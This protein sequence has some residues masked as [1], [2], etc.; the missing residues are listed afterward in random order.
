M[1]RVKRRS[2]LALFGGSPAFDPAIHVGRPN[3]GDRQA[4]DRLVREALDRRWLTN[5]GPLVRE[6]ERRIGEQLGVEHCVAV[7]N[8]TIGLEILFHALGLAGEVLVPSYTFIATAHALLRCGIKPIFVDIDPATHNIDPKAARARASSRTSGIVA[9]HLWGRPVPVRELQDLAGELGVP[10][11]FDAAHAFGCTFEGRSIGNFGAAEVLSFHATKFF[12]T[13][14]G[15]AVVTNDAALARE[16]RLLRNFGFS[17]YDN[18]MSLGTNGKMNEVCAAMGLVN[19]DALPAF[20]GR[21]RQIHQQYVEA[22]AQIPG[23]NVLRYDENERNNYQ[24]VVVELD[25]RFPVG[26]DRVVEA[27]HAEG[28]LARKY[29][30]PGCHRMMP[31]REIYP[32]EGAHLP[33]TE[34]VSERVLVLP[35]GTSLPDG[36]VG[37]Q[38]DIFRVLSE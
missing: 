16:L 19:L 4:F 31:Y 11:V 15:G 20:I 18:T 21:N 24:Y 28:I 10:L 36:A 34:A 29:F 38:A 26:R 2:D 3:I 22:F 32:G 6:L 8:G 25:E 1:K 35:T 27:L 9:V 17:G 5:D 14:E 23:V 12:N 37:L 33:V 13:L 7:C 30:W